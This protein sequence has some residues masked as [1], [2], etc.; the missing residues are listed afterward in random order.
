MAATVIRRTQEERSS[1]TQDKL[2]RAAFEL[3]REAGYA[4]FR[5]AS[6]AKAAG[7]SQGGQLHHFPTKDAMTLAAI[8]FGVSEAE[9]TTQG[10]FDRY[11]RATDPVDAIA[12]DAHDY[13]FSANFDV[14]LDVTKSASGNPDLRRAIATT[15]RR[16]R[17]FAEQGWHD[18]LVERGWSRADAKGLVAMTTSLVRGFAIRAMIRPDRHEVDRLLGRWRDMVYQTFP[19]VS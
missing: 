3:I 16:Y 12:D 6:V 17:D 10:H 8:E 18:L 15:S 14:S 4:N 5:V 13:Y 11:T 19:A 9:Y 1:E 7:V 2:A